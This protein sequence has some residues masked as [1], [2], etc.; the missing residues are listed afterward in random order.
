MPLLTEFS[1]LALLSR[2]PVP[3]MAGVRAC[4]AGVLST[5]PAFSATSAAYSTQYRPGAVPS[6]ITATAPA[7]NRLVPIIRRRRSH[8]SAKTPATG[9]R[10]RNGRYS[11][12]TVSPVARSEPVTRK[13]W[14]GMAS[15]SSHEPSE[16]IR[17]PAHSSRKSRIRSA[18]SMIATHPR[19]F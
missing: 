12:A 13:M 9:P 4:Q 16:L 19:L 18:W 14:V 3:T 1:A 17:P 8:R 2:E 10:S 15:V 11:A 6:S 5:T 7:Q